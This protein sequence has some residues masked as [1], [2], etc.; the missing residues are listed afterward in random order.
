MNRKVFFES[1]RSPLFRGSLSHS[2]VSGMENLLDVWESGY[3]SD[4][5]E[6]LA[7]NLA[8]AYHETARTMQPITERGAR[9]Y[10]NKYEP[11]TRLGR[12]LGNTRPGDGYRFRGEGHIF[13]RA[14]HK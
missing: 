5:I 3:R 10:F 13:R 9:S 6:H 12:R 14:E 11:G 8:T 1:I 7:Y 2:Q 4:P